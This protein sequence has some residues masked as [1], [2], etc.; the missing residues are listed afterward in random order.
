MNKLYEYKCIRCP[1]SYTRTPP[2]TIYRIRITLNNNQGRTISYG[3]KKK[4]RDKDFETITTTMVK[5]ETILLGAVTIN[6][7]FVVAVNKIPEVGGC[8]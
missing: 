3:T 7:E 5:K 4:D 2:P 1:H 8:D 6:P